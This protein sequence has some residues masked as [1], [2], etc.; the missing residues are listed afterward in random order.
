MAEYKAKA[1]KHGKLTIMPNIVN[2][3][4]GDLEIHMPSLQVISKFEKEQKKNK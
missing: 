3:P 2:K 4:N 1:D